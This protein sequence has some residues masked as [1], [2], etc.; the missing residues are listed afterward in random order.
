MDTLVSFYYAK[1]GWLVWTIKSVWRIILA[2]LVVIIC[3]VKKKH[4]KGVKR[5]TRRQ[6]C[7]KIGSDEDGFKYE[8]RKI[9]SKHN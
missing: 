9:Y 6:T 4:Q 2:K 1:K 5:K 8:T 3:F 7:I